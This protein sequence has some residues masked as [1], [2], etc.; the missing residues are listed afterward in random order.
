MVS[1]LLILSLLSQA[2]PV[3]APDAGVTVESLYVECGDAPLMEPVDGGF[4]VPLRRQQRN[5]C[6][7]AA[8]E[9]YANSKLQSETQEP[10]STGIVLVIIGSALALVGLGVVAG[11]LAPHP[12]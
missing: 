5:N 4:F 12:K 7:L 9:S 2:A 3:P 8:C 6:K 10:T 11:Y 1:K